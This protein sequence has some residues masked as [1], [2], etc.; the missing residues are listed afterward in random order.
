MDNGKETTIYDIALYLKVSPATVS[1]GLKGHPGISNKT[2]KKILD[3]AKLMGYRSNTFASNL[4]KKKTNTIGVIV[5]KLN[6]SFMSDVIAGIEE[7]ANESEYNLIISQSL[8]SEKKEI[9]N[10]ATMFNSRVDGLLVS[11]V[12]NTTSFSH[13][14]PF[15]EK[16]I[17]LIFFDR[18]FEHEKCSIIVI[19]NFKAAYDITSHLIQNGCKNIVHVTGNLS[20][21]VY[22]DRFKG[23]K[24][25]LTDHHLHFSDDNVIINNLSLREGIETA[26]RILKLPQLPDGVF[27]AN[28]YCAAGC[29]SEL[30]KKG[31]KIP[32]DIAF[33]GFN[34]DPVSNLIEP[35]L[36]TID[37]KGFE[38]GEIAART[39]I[40]HLNESQD[41]NQTQSIVMRHELI[42]RQS[43]LKIQFNNR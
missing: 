22:K 6:S 1:R 9:A 28:D 16:K 2:K 14:E 34:N 13:F 17:P 27:V 36:T 35:N 7:I 40:N 10:A 21:N 24:Q 20:R 42:I 5:P 43:S 11:L 39:L 15:I 8:E 18:V 4:R 31:V 25:A 38:M 32:N 29:M 26:E 37:Y 3:A 33:A 12:Y 30:K 41:I 23:F 19:N